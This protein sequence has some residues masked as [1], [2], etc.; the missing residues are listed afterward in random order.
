MPGSVP[1]HRIALD[2]PTSTPSATQASRI[3]SAE[4]RRRR[5]CNAGRASWDGYT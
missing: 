5:R 3:R 4:T 2:V 1:M